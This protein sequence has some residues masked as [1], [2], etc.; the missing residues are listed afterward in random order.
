MLL[1]EFAHLVNRVDAVQVAFPLRHAPGKQAVAAENDAIGF[2]MLLHGFFDHQR[3]FESRPLPRDPNE[4]APESPVELVHLL[5]AVGAGRKR[6][7]PV[8]TAICC[9]EPA[10]SSARDAAAGPFQPDG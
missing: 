1:N 7:S 8:R 5:L 3:K 9:P 2:G 10:C 4:L 6:N